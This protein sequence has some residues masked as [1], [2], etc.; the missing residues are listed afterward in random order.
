M[1]FVTTGLVTYLD[2]IVVNQVLIFRVAQ[3][4]LF[5]LS[6]EASVSQKSALKLLQKL[7][8]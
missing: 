2:R 7:C 5:T 6:I 1:T 8:D 4:L 3:T